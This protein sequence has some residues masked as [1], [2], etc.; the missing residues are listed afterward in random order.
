MK[1]EDQ[2]CSLEL[3]KRLKELR[4]NKDSLFV[5]ISII[6]TGFNFIK[7]RESFEPDGE[8]IGAYSYPAFT[9]AELG[10]LLFEKANEN[11]E[12]TGYFDFTTEMVYRTMGD[13]YRLTNNFFENII[14]ASKEA[15][16]RAILLIYLLERLTEGHYQ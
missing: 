5:W 1:L 2:V 3:S 15:D 6:K 12:K 16:A 13:F 10:E 11:I 9:V 14:D 8:D 4:I 7:L